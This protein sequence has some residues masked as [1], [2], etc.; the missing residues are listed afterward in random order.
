PVTLTKPDGTTVTTT[1]DANGNYE[2]TNLP[3]GEYTVEFGTPEGYAPTATNV[4]DD[5][6]DSDGQKVTV[7]VNNGDDLTIDSGFYKP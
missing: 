4:G 5:R 1:T 3:N 2:F 7:V 6:L